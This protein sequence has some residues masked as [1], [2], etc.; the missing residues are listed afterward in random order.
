M[1]FVDPYSTARPKV[2]TKFQRGVP[3]PHPHGGEWH[4][5]I[6]SSN[7]DDIN[8]NATAVECLAQIQLIENMKL[9]TAKIRTLIDGEKDKI[10]D[11]LRVNCAAQINNV[12]SK[13]FERKPRTYVAHVTD[14]QVQRVSN[15]QM[16]KYAEA[17]LC[18]SVFM[19]Q[20][21][22]F[23]AAVIKEVSILQN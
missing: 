13:E 5:M 6:T 23:T 19:G 8:G 16:A 11:E 22:A 3:F 4:C 1:K 21:D 18:D 14:V 17:S 20:T 7:A 15:D 10:Q 2:I 12:T 9:R